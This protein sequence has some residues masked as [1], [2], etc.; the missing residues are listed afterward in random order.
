MPTRASV[1]PIGVDHH[2]VAGD[3][4]ARPAR[5]RCPT[6]TRRSC[7]ASARTCATRTTPFALALAAALRAE[8]GWDGRLV[9]AGPSGPRA[10]APAPTGTRQRPSGSGPVAEDEKAWLLAHAAAVVYPT[11]YEGF[12]LI[13]FEAAAAGT[14]CL[15]AAWTALAEVL[16]ASAATLVAWDARASAAAVA[17]LLRDGPA[18][19]EHVAALR[20]AAERYR[21]DDTAP[22][23]RR[24]LRGGARAPPRELRRAPRERLA[25]EQRLQ[26]NEQAA[27]RGVAAPP[28]LPRADRQRRARARGARR[29]ARAGRPA[30]AARAAVAPLPA[31]SGDAGRP[32]RL[33]RSAAGATRASVS[34]HRPGV[35][36]HAKPRYSGPMSTPDAHGGRSLSPL[37]RARRQLGDALRLNLGYAIERLDRRMVETTTHAQEQIG[38]SLAQMEQRLSEALARGE[39]HSSERDAIIDAHA[40][41]SSDRLENRIMALEAR[42]EQL[43]STHYIGRD[44]VLIRHQLGFPMVLD[45][46][47]LTVTPYVLNGGYEHDLTRLWRELVD[48]GDTV[49]DIGANQG[50]H[51]IALAHRVGRTGHVWAF[52]PHPRT[53]EVLRENI[54]LNGLLGRITVIQAAATDGDGSRSFK[55]FSHRSGGSH[56][57]RDEERWTDALEGDTI[58]VKALD[59][60]AFAAALSEAPT[61]VKIDAEGEDLTILRRLLPSLP[62]SSERVYVM[63]LLAGD[64]D[65][66]AELTSFLELL[67]E[68]DLQPFAFQGRE[69]PEPVGREYLRGV[70]WEDVLLAHPDR[71]EE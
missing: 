56:L 2:V 61:L 37:R 24:P 42:L 11:L 51:T 4:G 13:P 15:F 22:R 40:A 25:L 44:R 50:L 19:D 53:V 30:R 29:R 49:L 12:G 67:A 63:E 68:Y 55:A 41:A 45:G 33:P 70:V 65:G 18:R 3:R 64:E 36:R 71:F 31:P 46:E 58:E 35:L 1:V 10:A 5:P 59:I 39:K 48:E 54:T 28:R 34:A 69:R 23:A 14:P 6:A 16:P 7:C 26:E 52:E 57:A 47:C 17:P 32:C 66:P 8:H 38:A 27:H 20:E 43:T 9:F 21:W 62:R 60:G